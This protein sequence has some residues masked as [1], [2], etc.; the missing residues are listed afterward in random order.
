VSSNERVVRGSFAPRGTRQ[1]RL[2]DT[3]YAINTESTG[4]VLTGRASDLC[5][6]DA[7]RPV[8]AAMRSS[9]SDETRGHHSRSPRRRRCIWP[10]VGCISVSAVVAPELADQ[11]AVARAF[12]AAGAEGAGK[13]ERPVCYE[14]KATSEEAT[15]PAFRLEI[16]FGLALSRIPFAPKVTLLLEA[17][18]VYNAANLSGFAGDLT[19]PGT[20]GQPV[21]R[22]T[23]VF[24]SGGPRSI[25]LGAR[26][27]F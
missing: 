11:A 21:S 26:F 10:G 4:A 23:Q 9:T 3:G 1:P 8:S 18:N 20:F 16:G 5:W 13:R 14:G 12:T 27:A 6:H 19:S 25:Q 22:A 2:E 17:F 24:G 15:L 7:K